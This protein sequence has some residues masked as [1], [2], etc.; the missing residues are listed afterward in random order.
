M[1]MREIV[2]VFLE[3]HEP[4]RAHEQRR[5]R[6]Q[7]RVHRGMIDDDIELANSKTTMT[8][9]LDIVKS[10]LRTNAYVDGRYGLGL[11]LEPTCA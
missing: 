3:R 10:T 8:M 6:G 2:F 1:I 5:V 9:M 7:V 11:R 4:E